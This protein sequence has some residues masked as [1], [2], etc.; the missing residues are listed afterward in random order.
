MTSFYVAV[1]CSILILGTLAFEI[2]TESPKKIA[3]MFMLYSGHN[4]MF[5]WEE[6]FKHADNQKYTIFI[7]EVQQSDNSFLRE[8]GALNLENRYT[9]WGDV[10]LVYLQTYMMRHALVDSYNE[11]FIFIS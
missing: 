1:I 10:S 5:I 11:K 3:F 8:Y 2:E 6:Y 7:H 9:E 4:N